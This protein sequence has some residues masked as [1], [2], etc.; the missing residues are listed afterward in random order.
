MVERGHPS[1]TGQASP[2]GQALSELEW[3]LL[4]DRQWEGV[5]RTPGGRPAATGR[6]VERLAGN[7]EALVKKGFLEEGGK[8]RDWKEGRD[9]SKKKK[10][11]GNPLQGNILFEAGEGKV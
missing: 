7:G 11:R 10:R 4:R 3:S 1:L 5:D 6:L 9:S 2:W 8:S